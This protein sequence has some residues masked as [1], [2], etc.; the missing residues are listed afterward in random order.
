M[1]LAR[2]FFF[3]AWTCPIIALLF[4][5]LAFD[6]IAAAAVA[7]ALTGAVVATLPSPAFR[8][9]RLLTTLLFPLTWLW[10]GYV[11]LNS[12]GPTAIDV[13]TT[14]ANTNA[15]EVSS[16]LNLMLSTQSI[17]V[18]ALQAAFLVGSYCFATAPFSGGVRNAFAVS[19]LALMAASWTQL[20]LSVRSSV[21]PARADWQN[22][23]YGSLIDIVSTW[24]A[25][26]R[27]VRAPAK[28]TRRTPVEQSVTQPIDAIF[29]VGETFRFERD[30]D[31]LKKQ[32]VWAPLA[33]RFAAN[34]GVMLPKVCASADATAIS[35]PMLMTGVPPVRNDDSATAP[36]GL[37]R[38]RAAG[39]MTAWIGMQEGHWLDDEPRNLRSITK[40]GYDDSLLPKLSAFLGRRDPRNKAVTL[41][42]MDS[43]APY[44]ERY[45]PLPEPD[46]LDREQLEVLRYHRANQHTL[47]FLGKIAGVLDDLPVP[48]FA[49][50]VS[51]HGEN[52]LAD[53]NGL[54][55]HIGA[56]T[57]AKAAYVPAFVFWNA[58]FR[59]AADP[60]A[61][62]ASD[63]AAPSLA[64]ADVY[65]IWMNFAGLDAPLDPTP[66]PKIFGKIELTD[67]KSAVACTRLK[68]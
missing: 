17:F 26:P 59:K 3:A 52:L 30:W 65:A 16:V 68:P 22:F 23:P 46:G 39:Y 14:M 31:E 29:I 2:P 55:F 28:L 67:Q 11:T 25:H 21:L 20:S 37:A 58:A 19:L 7:A 62:L 32:D 60:K 49:V 34:L 63:L 45:P 41:H 13:L 51:D 61:R 10:V 15:S 64:H 5:D 48:A 33:Q 43:H 47:Q 56:R 38:L 50:Y 1:P 4:G 9:A 44:V 42:L 53:H 27:F 35:V 54:H 12:T 66:E 18:G 57:T 24:V 36:S 6:R 8:I 40:G